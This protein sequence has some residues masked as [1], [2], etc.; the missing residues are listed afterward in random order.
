[1]TK[2][3]HLCGYC[4]AGFPTNVA[5]SCDEVVTW[6]EYH[7]PSWAPAHRKCTDECES[8][9]S[10]YLRGRAFEIVENLTARWSAE[11]GD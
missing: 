11:R 9:A 6:L 4:G 2:P 3:R 10:I 1:M 7:S 8:D 5:K